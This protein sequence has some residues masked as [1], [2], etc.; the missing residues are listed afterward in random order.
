MKKIGGKIALL[1]LCAVFVVQ[2]TACGGANGKC[3]EVIK[4]FETACN[5]GDV[6][7]MLDCITPSISTPAKLAVGVT[8]LIPGVDLSDTL[9]EVLGKIM[10]S[11]DVDVD[12]SSLFS[13]M[14]L[15]ITKSKK[16]SKDRLVYVDIS[17]EVLGTPINSYGVFRMEE[18]HKEWYIKSFQFVDSDE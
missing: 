15:D 7:G 18:D 11:T 10:K 5:D 8:N 2:A 13:T 12:A 1:L 14:K 17:Y 6:D 3:R 9:T 4:N 16:D